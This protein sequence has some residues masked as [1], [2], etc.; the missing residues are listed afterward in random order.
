MGETLSAKEVCK[1]AGYLCNHPVPF[2]V[3]QRS[4]APYTRSGMGDIEDDV[5]SSVA[6]AIVA[7]ADLAG[8]GITVARVVD[9]VPRARYVKRAAARWFGSAEA[10]AMRGDV[11]SA[12]S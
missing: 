10:H 5:P 6:S 4:A 2:Q 11:P 1:G 3:A 9:L 8:V 7:A 12:A